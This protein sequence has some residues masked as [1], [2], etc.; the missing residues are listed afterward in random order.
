MNDTNLT[1]WFLAH[2]ANP[3]AECGLDFTP[4]SVAVFEAPFAIIKLLFDRGGST[5]HGQLLHYAVRR[6]HADRVEVLKFII[7]KG[8]SINDLM[9]QNRLDC[10]EQLKYFGIGTP[11]HEAAEQGKQDV[12]ELLLAEGADPLIKDA[13]GELAI[14]RAQRAGRSAVVKQLLP[15]SSPSP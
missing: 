12:V 10:Y 1:L 5:K 3:N 7:S 13:K 2:G 9:Y 14:E 8:V 4:L 15:L 11:L 6:N